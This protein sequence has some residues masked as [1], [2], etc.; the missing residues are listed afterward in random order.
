M[1][2]K[3]GKKEQTIFYHPPLKFYN[4]EPQ[5]CLGVTLPQVQ[6]G[7]H[8]HT[9]PLISFLTQVNQ[10]SPSTSSPP[11]FFLLSTN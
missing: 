5:K 3:K 8:D 10:S 6:S 1:K 9:F 2:E 7:V 4:T 11:L